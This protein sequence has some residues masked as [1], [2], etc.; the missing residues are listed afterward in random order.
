MWHLF[1]SLC[2]RHFCSEERSVLDFLL[3]FIEAASSRAVSVYSLYEKKLIDPYWCYSE[4]IDVVRHVPLCF[5]IT[6]MSWDTK[7]WF[8]INNCQEIL[9]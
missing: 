5:R 1:V 4:M 8:L 6:M 7:N 9:G 2:Q 3:N